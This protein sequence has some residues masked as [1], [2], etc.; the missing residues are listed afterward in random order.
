MQIS[1]AL[2]LDGFPR[3][4]YLTRMFSRLCLFLLCSLFVLPTHTRARNLSEEERARC[5]IRST[6]PEYPEIARYQH[7]EGKG[8]Y[9]GFV[10]QETGAITKVVVVQSTGHRVLDDA[11]I[12]AVRHW[13]AK[14]HTLETFFVPVN[15]EMGDWIEDQLK[16]ARTHTTYAPAPVVPLGLAAYGYHSGGHYRLTI[17]PNTGRV[18]DVKVV[19]RS[20]AITFDQS[21]LRTFREWRFVPHTVSTLVVPASF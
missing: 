4:R 10:D 18:T 6:P 21:C 9:E 14:P 5:F 11:V 7:L 12:G 19:E 20:R 17:D 2:D 1:T 3:T 15:F 16:A 8:R 13:R